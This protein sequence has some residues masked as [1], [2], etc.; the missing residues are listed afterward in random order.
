MEITLTVPYL[1]GP[2]SDPDLVVRYLAS[3]EGEPLMHD[4]VL[5]LISPALL[6]AGQPLAALDALRALPLLRTPAEPWLP[7]FR[8]QGLDWPEPDRG[9]RLVDLGMVLE[10]AACGQG[11]A[12]ARPSIARAWLR[13][14]RLQPLLGGVGTPVSQSAFAYRLER[15]S[16]DPAVLLVAAW[17]CR[18]AA[19]AVAEGAALIA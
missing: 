17:L 19:A 13:S 4:P 16:D 9:P 10:A 2:V 12:L 5:P 11:V 6:P 3:D 18:S 8:A 14:G 7:W 1:E 15:G